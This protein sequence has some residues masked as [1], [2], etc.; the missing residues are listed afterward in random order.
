MVRK[1]LSREKSDRRAGWRG[2]PLFSFPYLHSFV[3]P[4]YYTCMSSTC[5]IAILYLRLFPSLSLGTL[6]PLLFTTRRKSWPFLQSVEGA[7][8][9]FEHEVGCVALTQEKW[10]RNLWRVRGEHVSSLMPMP[11]PTWSLHARCRRHPHTSC[12]CGPLLPYICTAVHCQPLPS[13]SLLGLFLLLLLS[14]FHSFPTINCPWFLD[15]KGTAMIQSWSAFL[16][17]G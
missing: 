4:S 5:I 7:K 10:G 8:G 14:F 17:L 9:N 16:S 2:A 13:L 1:D 12:H 11:C 15:L 6:G 3:G